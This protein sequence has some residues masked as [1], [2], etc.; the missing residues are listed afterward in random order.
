MQLRGPTCHHL[1]RLRRLEVSRSHK[2]KHDKPRSL[3]EATRQL[4]RNAQT[5]R[6]LCVE[7]PRSEAANLHEGS[8]IQGYPG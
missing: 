3:A 5:A 4:P 6:R 2:G 7:C 8:G 1:S